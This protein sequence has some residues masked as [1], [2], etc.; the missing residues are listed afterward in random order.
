MTRDEKVARR[1]AQSEW[2]DAAMRRVLIGA[3]WTI[4]AVWMFG[5]WGFLMFLFAG[6]IMQIRSMRHGRNY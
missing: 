3:V 4:P 2:A 6:N 5:G 1:I